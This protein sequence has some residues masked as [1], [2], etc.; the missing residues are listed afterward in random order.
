MKQKIHL[1]A[2]VK[3][4]PSH[5]DVIFNLNNLWFCVLTNEYWLLNIDYWLL[6]IDYWILNIKKIKQKIHLIANEKLHPSHRDVIFS[7]NNLWYCFLT[8]EYWL[9]NIEYSKKINHPAICL[10]YFSLDG[11]VTKRSRRKDIQPFSSFALMKLMNNGGF[12]FCSLMKCDVYHFFV[13]NLWFYFF[14]L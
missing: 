6:I 3:L 13:S 2:N 4:Y 11:K 9:L 5:R 12:N 7:L 14:I 8:N 1:I 10:C